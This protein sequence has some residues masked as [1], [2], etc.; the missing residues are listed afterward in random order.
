MSEVLG[1]EHILRVSESDACFLTH[2][3]SPVLLRAYV[4]TAAV[5]FKTNFNLR[6][7]RGIVNNDII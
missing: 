6:R 2:L 4:V 7:R 1:E 3:Y 5:L